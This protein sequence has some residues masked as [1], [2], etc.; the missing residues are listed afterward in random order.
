MSQQDV[1]AELGISRSTLHKW[2]IEG[3]GPS[4]RKLP[5]GELRIRRADLHAWFLTLEEV[6]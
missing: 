6:E 2:R 5:N 1:L 4:F 3:R